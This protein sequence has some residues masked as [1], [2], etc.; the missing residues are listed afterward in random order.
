MQMLFGSS[1]E[2]VWLSQ[3]LAICTV[4]MSPPISQIADL[5]GRKWPV[6]L[7]M[8]CAF[9]GSIVSSR[10]NSMGTVTAGFV[11]IGVSFGSQALLHAVVSEVL[12][13]RQRPIAQ[14]ILNI[15]GGLGGFLGICI[16]AGL[17]RGGALENFRI[18]LYVT[19]ASFF[20]GAMGIVFCYNPPPRELQQTLSTRKKI[21]SLDW[22][23]YLLFGAGLTLFSIA[24]SWSQNPY[25]WSNSRI[26]APF[27]IGV[28][29]VIAFV[30]YEWRF[31]KDGFMNHALFKERNFTLAL[32][33]VFTE[34][35][36]FFAANSYFA[37]EVGIFTG[38]DLLIVGLHYGITFLTII[39]FSGI[40]SIF[41]TR[42]KALRLPIFVGF[43]FILVFNIV[44]AAAQPLNIRAAFWGLGVILGVGIGVMLPLIMV[45]AQLSSP[46]ELISTASALIV[47]ARCFGG[48]IG[49][50][51]NNA[52]YNST[53]NSEL[54]KQVAEA[55]VPLGLP[56][57]SLPGLIVA[58]TTQNE[59]LLANVEGLTPTI[60]TAASSA[61]LKAFEMTFR[62]C[63]IAAACFCVPAAI[64]KL[65]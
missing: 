26:I 63:W 32:L 29:L 21:Q 41:S 12:P 59:E 57:S 27:V 13:R 25:P 61:V 62:N 44:L 39:V 4:A 46:P 42:Y 18:Y 48:T 10:A 35:L 56:T 23:G 30:I 8:L 47:A 53:L 38:Q 52:L 3:A 6:V 7:S 15:I 24:L 22:A 5:W 33:L 16:G 28:V 31:K 34:G 1:N 9:T 19:A 20:V 17:I 64:G 54:P 43:V 40:V 65:A 55:T 45:V 51:V 50:A 60:L 11:L 14:G 37:L 2:T 36:A 58:L 49:L